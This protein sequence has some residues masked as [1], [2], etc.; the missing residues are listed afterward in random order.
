M[1]TNCLQNS[2]WSSLLFETQLHGSYQHVPRASPPPEALSATHQQHKPD[3][4]PELLGCY[5]LR[6]RILH[7]VPSPPVLLPSAAA[8][9]E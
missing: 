9:L 5:A 7:R 8:S 6:D 2:G 4:F 3:S 1:G